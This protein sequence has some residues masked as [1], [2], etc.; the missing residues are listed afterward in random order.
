LAGTLRV[1]G[2]THGALC[3]CAT[4]RANTTTLLAL[5]LA[6]ADELAIAETT[7]FGTATRLTFIAAG[8]AVVTRQAG[9]TS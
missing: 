8:N 1:A 3:V 7:V 6:V 4:W 2:Q 5:A 9:D